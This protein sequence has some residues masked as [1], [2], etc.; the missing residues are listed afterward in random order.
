VVRSGARPARL[1]LAVGIAGTFAIGTLPGHA[2]LPVCPGSVTAL[3]DRWER[4]AAPKFADGAANVIDYSLDADTDHD[5]VVTNGTDIYVSSDA[6]CQ[7]SQSSVPEPLPTPPSLAGDLTP[8]VR[9]AIRQVKMAPAG[10]AVWAIGVTTLVVNGTPL[11][12]PRVLVSTDHGASFTSAAGLP[13][14]GEPV[15]IAPLG[16]SVA[17][18]LFRPTGPKATTSFYVTTDGGNSWT[19]TG[20]GLPQ[21]TGF[22][23]GGSG[24]SSAVWAWDNNTLYRSTDFG[25]HFA[26]VSAVRGGVRTVDVATAFRRPPTVTVFMTSGSR[27]YV[28]VDGGR[29]FHVASAPAGV[30]SVTHG[31]LAGFLVVSA[32]QENVDVEPPTATRKAPYDASP[33]E[34]NVDNVQLSQTFTGSGFVL[35]AAN[36]GAL[37]RLR[38]PV[39][40]PKPPPPPLLP[41]HVSPR[42]A[43]RQLPELSPNTRLVTL[44]PHERRRIP[45]QL[46]L[47]PSPT[48]L[49]VYFM[50][51]S[52][53]S[54]AGAIHDVQESVQQIV[55]DLAN[56]GI[57]VNFGVAD[58]RDYVNATPPPEMSNYPY[59]RRRAVGPINSELSDA[60][61]S[62]TTGGGTTD[63][64]DSGLEAL[65][66]AGTGAGRLDPLDPTGSQYLIQPGQGANF[67]KNAVKVVL[68][69]ADDEF[70]HPDASNAGGY[71]SPGYPGPSLQTVESMLAGLD[72]HV[73]GIKVNTNSGDP[74]A[75]M[76]ALAAATQTFATGDGVDC[77]GDGTID[78]PAGAPLVCP[79]TPGSEDGI[80]PAFTGL[81]ESVRD[82]AS[83]DLAVQGPR[84][85]VRPL[86][87]TTFRDVNVK[88]ANRLRVPV[89]FRCEGARFGTDTTVDMVARIKGRELARLPVDVRCLSPAQP[90]PLA[91]LPALPVLAAAIAP[92]PPPAQGPVNPNP[93]PNPQTQP[94]VGAATQE[95]EQ[96]EL[97]LAEG[98]LSG[99]DTTLAMSAQRRDASGAPLFL[100]A[101]AL[102]TAAAGC[103]VRLSRRTER[104]VSRA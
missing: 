34:A 87:P 69:A 64:N 83:V 6:G 1:V 3:P 42:S 14:D 78:V 71:I 44:R 77:D 88:V 100:G 94:N 33:V 97:A 25:G 75:D 35:Y 65:Y 101:A 13:A 43:V 57:D 84:D 22:S 19:Q 56:S 20:T 99:D 11:A 46:L 39:S 74:S 60:L 67:R 36:P 66:Q 48:P 63:G 82:F 7:W 23:I 61:Q 102:M 41:V 4:I 45:Y 68:V 10:G 15:S 28:S 51:D 76:R 52:T 24:A 96:S 49:D 30:T 54:M 29:S 72:V 90:G 9:S 59:K 95:E 79:Y 16:G 31:P 40:F 37:W 73:V 17:V 47:P 38:I 92:P 18:L 5:L 93:Q 26:T 2:A 89:E 85:V 55:D 8:V 103:C 98:E 21:L 62:I 32:T 70:R 12:Q 58:F 50:T 80:T 91:A 27:R 53:G 104:G 81:L 86:A